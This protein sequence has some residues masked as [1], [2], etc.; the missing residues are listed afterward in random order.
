[1]AA[2]LTGDAHG[3]RTDGMVTP[4]DRWRDWGGDGPLLHFAHAN[5]FPPAAYAVL[6]DRLAWD[7][8]VVSWEG[9]PLWPGSDPTA[10]R[11]WR[12][13]AKDLRNTLVSRGL[14]GLI[15]VGHSLGAVLS[16]M[17]AHR[18]P[19]LFT[20]LVLID[21]VIFSG[22][23]ARGWA[24]M[25]AFGRGDRLYLVRGAKGR[26]QF[27]PD[28]ETARSSW[29]AKRTFAGWVDGALDDYVE[30]GLVEAGDGRLRL[31]YPRTWEAR[32][33]ELTPHDLWREVRALD[34]PILAIRGETSDT[35]LKGA[36]R[37][38]ERVGR[39]ARVVEIPGTGHMVPMQAP[40]RVAQEIRR[41]VLE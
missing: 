41:F 9:R 5:G 3:Y 6:L 2:S 40:E 34:L 29:A 1:M 28:R 35:F 32:I 26:R 12:P 19:D 38:L 36:A 33:F 21:P 18:R 39:R 13:L 15:G 16:L 24:L 27:W 4:H 11:S 17:A 20:A 22:T 23:R 8:H 37:K 14:R 30:D 31:R 10:I 7:F 25:K